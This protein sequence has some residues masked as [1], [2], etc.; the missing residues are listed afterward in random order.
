[1]TNGTVALSRIDWISDAPPRGMR[2]STY[3]RS[4]MNSTAASRLTSSTSTRQSCGSPAFS[5]P[6][7]STAGDGGV[8]LDRRRRAPEERDVARLQAQAEGVAGDVGTRLVDDGDDAERHADLVDAEAVGPGPALGDLADGIGERGHLAEAAGHGGDALLGRG[9][10]GRA[11]PAAMPPASSRA[12]SRALAARISPA[13]LLEEVGGSVQRG[14]LR[15]GGGRGQR[16][17]RGLGPGAELG[18]GGGGHAP[19]LGG[20]RGR[21]PERPGRAGP[22]GQTR[23][24]GDRPCAGGRRHVVL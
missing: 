21:L 15:V 8:R 22:V 4:C 19:S 17:G 7:R 13:R 20:L 3:W 1:M 24:G 6:S 18:N 16:A 9:A 5:R 12:R 2:Q 11:G 14:V 23:R 10:A